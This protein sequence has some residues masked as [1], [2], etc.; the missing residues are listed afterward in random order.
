[1]TLDSRLGRRVAQVLPRGGPEAHA[2]G[3]RGL[4]RRS[5]APLAWPL[6]G[7]DAVRAKP[8]G[9]L[10]VVLTRE[11]GRA[12]VGR[13]GGVPRL[14][15]VL[16]YGA[17]LRLLECARLRIKDVDFGANQIVVRRGKGDRDRV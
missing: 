8:P 13:M 1:M 9:G 2:H 7:W 5:H 4:L 17:G 3:S 14:M 6:G 15:A 16:L 10:P 11:E 12:V